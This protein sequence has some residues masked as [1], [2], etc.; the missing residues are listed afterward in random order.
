MASPE[1]F[2]K[3]GQECEEKRDADIRTGGHRTSPL[4]W[5]RVQLV[6]K[7][8]EGFD[9][10]RGEWQ[11][12]SDRQRWSSDIPLVLNLHILATDNNTKRQPCVCLPSL[13]EPLAY[14]SF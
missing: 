4:T 14:G 3:A 8:Q 12:L 1:L 2:S 11:R 5:L 7:D 9:C 10:G 6:H 13:L